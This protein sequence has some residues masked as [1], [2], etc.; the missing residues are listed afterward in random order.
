MEPILLF[1]NQRFENMISCRVQGVFLHK[2]ARVNAVNNVDY[3]R[4]GFN[5]LYLAISDS[6]FVRTKRECINFSSIHHNIYCVNLG[7]RFFL[8]LVQLQ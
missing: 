5:L 7:V 1:F 8:S 4:L 2:D 6:G 3:Q